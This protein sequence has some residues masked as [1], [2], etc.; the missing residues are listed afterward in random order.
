M[1][2]TNHSAAAADPAAATSGGHLSR[3]N[4]AGRGSVWDLSGQVALVTG[5]S[6]GIGRCTAQTLAAAGAAVV[7]AARNVAALDTVVGSITADGGRALAVPF[8]SL[9]VERSD[10]LVQA[11]VAA[12][13]RLDI[14]VNNVGGSPPRPFLDTS[15]RSF[16]R[17]FRFN[18]STAFALT[19][20]AVPALR[21]T[22]GG[23]V[24]NI[25]SGAG[26][27]ASPG[28]A[29][30]GTAKAALAHLTRILAAELAPDIRVNLVAPGAIAT[31]ALET[32]LTDDLRASMI[33][34][35]PLARLGRPEDIADAVLYLCSSAGSYVTGKQLEVDGGI[36]DSNLR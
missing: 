5:A 24:V 15:V 3:P 1:N 20:A 16:E 9:E 7:V 27:F 8:D 29:A 33:A 19:Q 4:P 18:V 30:Y 32:V 25:G 11:T 12:F 36:N 34:N 21:E 6:Q 35:T 28:F 22:G 17:A 14:V 23:A 2:Q 26:R 13:G 10:E 31:D